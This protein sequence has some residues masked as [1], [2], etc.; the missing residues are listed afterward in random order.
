[1][2]EDLAVFSASGRVLVSPLAWIQEGAEQAEA[3]E[4]VLLGEYQI[5]GDQLDGLWAYVR[6]KGEKKLPG[7]RRKLTRKTLHAEIYDDPKRRWKPRTPAMAV[8][9]TDHIWTAKE[10]LTTAVLPNNT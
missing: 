8:G 1:M 9:L 6:N 2:N 5:E 10:L 7:N 3:I 4:E